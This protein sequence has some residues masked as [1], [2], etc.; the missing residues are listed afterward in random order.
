MNF[1]R[2]TIFNRGKKN[3]ARNP[4]K[5]CIESR[6]DFLQSMKNFAGP[7][8][9]VLDDLHLNEYHGYVL[10]KHEFNQRKMLN[11]PVVHDSTNRIGD[12][13]LHASGLQPR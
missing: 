11:L 1:P 6:K 3:T 2:Q 9:T 10:K 4:L 5:I 8:D 13:F 7:S 12:I